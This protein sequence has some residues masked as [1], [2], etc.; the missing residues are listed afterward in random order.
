MKKDEKW[1]RGR[2]GRG[3]EERGREKR[4]KKGGR[5]AVRWKTPNAKRGESAHVI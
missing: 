4:I 1:E 5:D 2:E 3:R